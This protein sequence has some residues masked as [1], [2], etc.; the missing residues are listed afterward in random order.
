MKA[1]LAAVFWC[2]VV[3]A[4]FVCIVMGICVC[5]CACLHAISDSVPVSLVPPLAIHAQHDINK[6][7]SGHVMA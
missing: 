4:V 1:K 7:A 3:A 5:A 6:P 2:V